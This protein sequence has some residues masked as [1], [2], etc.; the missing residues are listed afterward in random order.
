MK[1]TFV[2]LQK[3][4]LILFIEKL[5]VVLGY[6]NYHHVFPYDYSTGEYSWEVCLA[7]VSGHW[8]ETRLW[9]WPSES[10]ALSNDFRGN[11]CLS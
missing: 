6:H 5:I 7:P 2:C 11:S 8:P 9:L 4:V 3:F 1:T 10:R